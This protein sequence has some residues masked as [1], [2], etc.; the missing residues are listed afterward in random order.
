M[1][2]VLFVGGPLDGELRQVDLT[3][4]VIKAPLYDQPGAPTATYPLQRMV[5]FGSFATVGVLSGMSP[6]TRD[7]RVRQLLLSPLAL[8]LLEDE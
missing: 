4:Q 3:S 1:R 6:G 5:L 2:T 7:R 8:N